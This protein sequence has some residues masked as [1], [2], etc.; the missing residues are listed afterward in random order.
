MY[1]SIQTA[2]GY[3]DIRAIGNFKRKVRIYC[4]LLKKHDNS[5]QNH[6]KGMNVVRNSLWSIIFVVI[7]IIFIGNFMRYIFLYGPL[8][9]SIMLHFIMGISFFAS[10]LAMLKQEKIL[11]A[12]VNLGGIVIMVISLIKKIGLF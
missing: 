4:H 5:I 7:F 2:H 1:G 3:Q 10:F 9:I 6:I 11:F 8:D 12:I